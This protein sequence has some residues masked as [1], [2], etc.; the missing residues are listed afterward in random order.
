MEELPDFSELDD[1]SALIQFLSWTQSVL[2]EL[3]YEG[4][5]PTGTELF[6]EELRDPMIS[7]WEEVSPQ[8][9]ELMSATSDLSEEALIRH[10]LFGPQLR[11]K[12]ATIRTKSRAFIRSGSRWLLR[13]L[14]SSIDTLLDSI[15]SAVSFGTAISELKDAVKDAIQDEG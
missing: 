7:A 1:R 4:V 9:E 15:L 2:N 6:Y 8:F 14:L 13:R 5:S 3:I 12:F 11:F 10:G